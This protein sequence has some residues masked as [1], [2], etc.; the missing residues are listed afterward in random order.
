M[1]IPMV[2]PAREYR[3]LKSE[4]DAAV[5]RV[6]ASGRFVLG[7]EG[8]SLEHELAAFLGAGH[9]VGVNSGTDALHLPL[10]AAGIGPGD[11][12][13]TSAFSFQATAGTIARL[14]A[15]PVFV[16]IDSETFN[17]DPAGFESRITS[18]TRALLPV[19]LF[20][21][22][23][24]MEQVLRVASRH[25]LLVI[26]DAA[27]A[28]GAEVGGKRAGGI[29]DAGCFSFYPTKNLGGAGDGG[30]ITTNNTELAER[31]RMLRD[32]GFK[33][34][35][36]AEIL[37][38]NFR[39]D[40]IQAAVLRVKFRY[41]DRWTKAR[42]RNAAEYR[43]CLPPEIGL[44][45]EKSGSHVYHQFV[46]R[47]PRR[48]ALIEHLREQKIGCEVYYPVPLHLQKCFEDLRHRPGDF[49]ISEQAARETLALPIY[50]ELTPEMIQRIAQAIARV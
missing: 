47:H 40:A 27:Q 1:N 38:G 10:V 12:V 35:Y 15:I 13:I 28:I 29:G 33:K 9:A 49:P 5:G 2:D 45:A 3:E 44:P 37:G 25:K 42:Q 17:I 18:R 11:E 19:H 22:M 50:P 32:H 41:L 8:E 14:G 34:R 24:D 7:P 23:S 30:M 43:K 48:D 31:L 39:L 36:Y 6:L 21:Q 20:G 16:D 4:I 46:I 26:E